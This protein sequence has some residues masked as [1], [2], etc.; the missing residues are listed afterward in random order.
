MQFHSCSSTIR[1]E[2]K[3]YLDLFRGSPL[4]CQGLQ[5]THTPPCQHGPREI[6][7][8]QTG[9]AWS[10]Y[11]FM[12]LIW[13]HFCAVGK[14]N[15]SPFGLLTT[16]HS[17]EST[18]ALTLSWLHPYCT[19]CV[20][21]LWGGQGCRCVGVCL[22]ACVC[23]LCICVC[24]CKRAYAYKQRKIFW[25]CTGGPNSGICGSQ[26]G[27]EMYPADAVCVWNRW[28]I[29]TCFT[30]EKWVLRLEW[31]MFIPL[32]QTEVHLASALNLLTVSMKWVNSYL[33]CIAATVHK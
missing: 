8:L 2:I 27:W 20:V 1:N 28:I 14:T 5:H 15:V 11:I 26:F 10:M 29:K 24:V 19:N 32:P 31:N 6:M 12:D 33:F 21:C 3:L 4:F 9:Q 25:T 18:T 17:L 23:V 30:D 7:C 13:H 22:H 16:A